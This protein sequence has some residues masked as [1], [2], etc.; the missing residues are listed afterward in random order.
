MLR[1][2]CFAFVQ[3]YDSI[4]VAANGAA[5]FGA[6]LLLRTF[7]LRK[8]VCTMK[9][10]IAVM[11]VMTVLLTCLMCGC[12]VKIDY[13]NASD[14]E[15]ALNAGEDVTGKTVKFTVDAVVPDSAFGYNLQAGEHLNFC[16]TEDP[17][18]SAGDTVTVEITSV[19]SL[20]GSYI[21]YYEM[22]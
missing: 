21:I 7:Y 16:S 18:A 6:Q 5:F 8:E 22:K 13:A 19:S 20:L 12:G 17:K 3:E 10:A 9:R 11:L 14:L 15:A 1:F 4:C 2:V